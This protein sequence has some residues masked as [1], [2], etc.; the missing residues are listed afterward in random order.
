M[1]TPAASI[2]SRGPIWA[3]IRGFRLALLAFERTREGERVGYIIECKRYRRDRKVTLREAHVLAAKRMHMKS[4]GFDKAMLVTTS[5]FTE[6]ARKLYDSPWG[7][8]LKAYDEVV[9]WLRHY[10]PPK[11]GYYL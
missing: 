11:K 1:S 9:E 10:K 7:L 2:P 8:E 5:D 3:P 4:E 6:P